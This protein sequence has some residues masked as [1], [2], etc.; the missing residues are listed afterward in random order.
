M[1]LDPRERLAVQQAELVRALTGQV[2]PPE[3]FIPGQVRTAALALARKRA[4]SVARAWPSLVE[5]LGPG[6]EP[7]FAS[8]ATEAPLPRRGGPLADGRNFVRSLDRQGKLSDL[9]R[10][11]ALSVD[12]HYAS[13]SVGLVARR[14][15]S[16]AIA[17]LRHP[18]RLILAARW[19]GLRAR[20]IAV[21][22][23]RRMAHK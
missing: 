15:P 2:G 21:P 16:L 11:E 3:A 22:L 5:T 7:C 10:L 6:F 12:L 8:Y 14:G 1:S 23:G 17:L 13:R 18:R 4:R 20:R 19:P 9:A